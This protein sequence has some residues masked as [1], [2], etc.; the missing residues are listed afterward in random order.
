MGKHSLVLFHLWRT[1]LWAGMGRM[2]VMVTYH[3]PT[4]GLCLETRHIQGWVSGSDLASDFPS[5]KNMTS[6]GKN[7][8]TPTVIT[9]VRVRSSSTGTRKL[10]EG[11][12]GENFSWWGVSHT[13]C[14][15]EPGHE[16]EGGLFIYFLFIHKKRGALFVFRLFI[17]GTG[18]H[19][20][21]TPGW[22]PTHSDLT[23]THKCCYFFF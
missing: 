12:E 9:E 11:S 17:W 4:P 20:N 13:G 6:R 18:S 8:Y 16:R 3:S 22:P 2:F 15:L 14:S 1:V 23:Q 7:K 5:P 19:Y 10:W 21:S